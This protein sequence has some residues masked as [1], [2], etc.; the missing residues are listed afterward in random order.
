MIP[1]AMPGGSLDPGTCWFHFEG[2]VV[3]ERLYY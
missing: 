3:M 2:L 1:R